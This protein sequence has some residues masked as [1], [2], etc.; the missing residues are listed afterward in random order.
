MN[1][2]PRPGTY[3]SNSGEYTIVIRAYDGP[4]SK[5][6]AEYSTTS[7]PKGPLGEGGQ[8]FGAYFWINDSVPKD[9]ATPSAIRF[10][11]MFRPEGSPYC[12]LDSWTG[13]YEEDDSMLLEGA[14]S[15]ID[16]D[17]AQEVYS[18][19]RQAFKLEQHA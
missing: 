10:D 15:Y 5:V 16:E 18:L 12:I 13:V 9:G 14:R 11:T 17:G 6:F 19:G 2:N 4:T 1:M 8:T 7:S 3:A